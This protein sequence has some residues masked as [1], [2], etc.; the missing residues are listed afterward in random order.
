MYGDNNTF[1]LLRRQGY[2][3]P[4]NEG[5]VRRVVFRNESTD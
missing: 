3:N 2:G 5:Y 1:V 4:N